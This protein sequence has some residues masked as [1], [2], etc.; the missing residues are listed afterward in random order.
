MDDVI[1]GG[2]RPRHSS[3]GDG[4]TELFDSFHAR[5]KKEGDMNVP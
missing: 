1:F 5:N 4:T 3:I 2:A